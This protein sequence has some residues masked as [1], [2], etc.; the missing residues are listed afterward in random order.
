VIVEHAATE[1]RWLAYMARALE[2]GL[3]AQM[4]PQL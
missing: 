2:T 4:G 3:Q 1:Q